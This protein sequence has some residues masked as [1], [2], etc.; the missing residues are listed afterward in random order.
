M[1]IYMILFKVNVII[2]VKYI[3]KL[4]EYNL[5]LDCFWLNNWDI[6]GRNED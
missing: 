5:M 4:V 6:I 2:L 3:D 1:K